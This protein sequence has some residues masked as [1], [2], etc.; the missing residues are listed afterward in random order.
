MGADRFIPVTLA[1]GGGASRS[2]IGWA[3]LIFNVYAINFLG[4]VDWLAAHS[5]NPRLTG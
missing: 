3:G 2:A 5:A 4:T 1:E